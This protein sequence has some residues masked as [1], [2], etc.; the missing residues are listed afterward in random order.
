MDLDPQASVAN[1]VTYGAT[2]P[3]LFI[4]LLPQVESML[5]ALGTWHGSETVGVICKTS[6]Q[7]PPSFLLM[8]LEER[9]PS[10]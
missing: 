8:G 2:L 5:L 7:W 10:F 9:N 4:A 3:V 6:S 1:P